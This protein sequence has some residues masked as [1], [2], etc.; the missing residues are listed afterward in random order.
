MNLK[1]K[2]LIGMLIELAAIGSGI[3]FSGTE[4]R[5]FIDIP[6]IIIVAGVPLAVAFAS[7]P[8][9]RIG[10]AF[11]APVDPAASILDLEDSAEFLSSFRRWMYAGTVVCAFI[12]LIA[13]L[14]YLHEMEPERLA[15]NVA[16]A[17]LCVWQAFFFDALFLHP[18]EAAACR[19]LRD[20]R[21]SPEA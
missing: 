19:R 4:P 8:V 18:L 12:G 6:T 9:K 2:L 14:R 20:G 11:A 17:V 7:W 1:A 3:L 16:V 21:R 10:R 15:P 5:I 13:I